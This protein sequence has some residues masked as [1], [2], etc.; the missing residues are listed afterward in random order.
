MKVGGGY[1]DQIKAE[2]F[3]VLTKSN[4]RHSLF[5]SRMFFGVNGRDFPKFLPNKNL[6]IQNYYEQRNSSKKGHIFNCTRKVI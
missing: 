3:R 2:V 5:N 6:K 4:Q 1:L